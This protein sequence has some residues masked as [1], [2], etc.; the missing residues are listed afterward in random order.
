MSDDEREY[1][2]EEN[3]ELLEKTIAQLEEDD[4]P[5]EDAFLAYTKGM[6][7]LKKCNA[8]IDKVEKK[9]LELSGTEAAEETDYGSSEV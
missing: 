7:I 3:F 4:I 9:V 8:Q 5:L 2:L 6:E 1:T